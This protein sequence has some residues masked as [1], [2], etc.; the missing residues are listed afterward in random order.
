MRRAGWLGIGAPKNTRPKCR[1]AQINAGLVLAD[2][3]SDFGRYITQETQ[4]WGQVIRAANVKASGSGDR[5][6]AR[7]EIAA[8]FSP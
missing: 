8:G 6:R 5:K 7:A 2:S 3:P 4:K 1:E